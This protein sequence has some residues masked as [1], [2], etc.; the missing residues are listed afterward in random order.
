ME[1]KLILPGNKRKCHAVLIRIVVSNSLRLQA[2]C[3]WNSSGKNTGVGCLAL[4][5]GIFLT[6]K[7]NIY[8]LSHFAVQQKLTHCK[9]AKLKQNKIFKELFYQ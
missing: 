7:L 6:Q 4:L 1:S 8:I 9:S 5:Q 2:L 3:P